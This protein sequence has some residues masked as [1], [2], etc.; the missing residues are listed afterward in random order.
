MSFSGTA[1]KVELVKALK[2]KGTL[3]NE[4]LLAL[5]QMSPQAG[6]YMLDVSSPSP[7][8]TC[9]E[10]LLATPGSNPSGIHR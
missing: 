3:K 4:D 2:R 8:L 10:W 7:S 1:S 5:Q 6:Y 9:I